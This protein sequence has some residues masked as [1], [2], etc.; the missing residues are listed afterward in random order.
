M[1]IMY[2]RL[3]VLM[4]EHNQTQRSLSEAL[5]LGTHTISKLY[6]NTFQ[7]VDRETIHKLINFFGCPLEGREGLF[8]LKEDA[9]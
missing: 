7:R 4:A 2:C 1:K 9:D 8:M 5:G 6:N 3:K